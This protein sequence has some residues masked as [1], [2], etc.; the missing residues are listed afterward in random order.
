MSPRVLTG[1]RLS[2]LARCPR[3]CAL[4]GLGAEP[5]EPST[6]A[7]RWMARGNVFGIYAALQYEHRY[8]RDSV[9]R[10]RDVPW[11]LGTGHADIYVKPERLIVE[12]V[13]STSPHGL[14]AGK[15]RQARQYLHYDPEAE[16]AAVYVI[17]PS[18]LDAEELL[19]V[20]LRPEDVAEIEYDV[21]QVRH[22]LDGGSLPDCSA[23]TPDE[24]R[25]HYFCPFTERAWADWEPP[26]PV[27]LAAD[28]EVFALARELFTL[29]ERRRL[30]KGDDAADETRQKEIEAALCASVEPG[31]EY[32]IGPLKVRRTAVKGRETFNWSAAKASGLVSEE[33]LAPFVKVGNGYD[34]F[35]VDRVGDGPLVLAEDFGEVAPF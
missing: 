17:D 4:R 7:R 29:K 10:E 8:G 16:R 25:F 15:F 33:L 34:T 35:R 20:V 26:A 14:L 12:V 18:D 23:A 11:P 6:R 5:A 21:A 28:P 22:A 30:R 9:Q 32:T 24:C 19:P 1:L 3:M 13:S 2:E 27:D 31:L